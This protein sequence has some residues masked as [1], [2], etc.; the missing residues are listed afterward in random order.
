MILSDACIS[1]GEIA[2]LETLYILYIK[3]Y[4]VNEAHDTAG[5]TLR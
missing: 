2:A 5:S 4:E 3:C 1:R